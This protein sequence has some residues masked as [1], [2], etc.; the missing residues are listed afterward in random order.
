MK[1]TED[2][3]TFLL[4]QVMR[5][6]QEVTLT[7]VHFGYAEP[8][9]EYSVPLDFMSRITASLD[10]KNVIA[11]AYDGKLEDHPMQPGDILFTGKHGWACSIGKTPFS[12]AISIV[13]MESYIRLVYSEVSY[14]KV[15]YNPWYHTAGGPREISL[16]LI[17]CLNKL[18]FETDSDR[19]TRAIPLLT[20]LL[21]QVVEEVTHDSPQKMGKADRTFKQVVEYTHQY[22]HSPINRASVC[23]ELN[24]NPCYVS[25]IFKERTGQHFNAYLNR[26]RME[27]AET[28]L[29]KYDLS[30]EQLA[31]LC[32][33]SSAGYFI[34]AFKKFYGIT[35]GEFRH[36]K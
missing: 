11:A 35:P 14:G 30:I 2:I 12:A 18:M 13:F 19:Q 17:Q 16:H 34:K 7:K 26:L 1:N 3:K 6:L 23:N 21:Y 31:A 4:K 25:K 10:G 9:P 28:L 8:L 5:T 27:N 20:A 15:L 24:L 36:M 33:F 22:C 32:G 29:Q